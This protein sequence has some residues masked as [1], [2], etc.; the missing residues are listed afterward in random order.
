MRAHIAV[1][2]L[3][4]TYVV[5]ALAVIGASGAYLT[6][7]LTIAG[8]LQTIVTAVIGMTVRAG[9]TNEVKKVGE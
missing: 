1:H 5:G 4:L 8:A 3:H 9:V 7:D 2:G 6:G